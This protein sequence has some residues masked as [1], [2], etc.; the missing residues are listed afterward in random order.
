M[1]HQCLDLNKAYS[2]NASYAPIASPSPAAI[3]SV[4]ATTSYEIVAY[5]VSRI[6]LGDACST[7]SHSSNLDWPCDSMDVLLAKSKLSKRNGRRC[8]AKATEELMGRARKL[9]NDFLRL[10]AKSKLSERNGSCYAKATKELMGRARMLENDFLRS[11]QR[12]TLTMHLMHQLL[13]PSPAAILSVDA[14][15]S[16][17][18][19]AYAVSRIALGDTCSTV[20]HSSN[21]DWPC[22]SMTFSVTCTFVVCSRLLAKSKLSKRNGRRCYAKATEELM[23]RARKLE[24]DFL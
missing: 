2:D 11:K 4:D 1:D 16:Y 10:L 17:E 5:A 15:T 9:E 22:D 14:T 19:V 3:L 7:V 20:S 12:L 13:P 6:A 24:N 8:Y 21:L 23:G 18:I